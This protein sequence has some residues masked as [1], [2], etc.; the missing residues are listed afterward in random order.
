MIE[1]SVDSDK[2][3]YDC[4]TAHEFKAKP[5]FFWKFYYFVGAM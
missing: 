3:R 2:Y 4:A 5:S 1:P